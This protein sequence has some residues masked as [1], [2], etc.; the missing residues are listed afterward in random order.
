[1]RKIATFG[2]AKL[3]CPWPVSD[4]PQ[5]QLPFQNF[6]FTA[7][8]LALAVSSVVLDGSIPKRDPV[9]V[10]PGQVL[11]SPAASLEARTWEDPLT[12]AQ[13]VAKQESERGA[14]SVGIQAPESVASRFWTSFPD[15]GGLLV[16]P[17]LLPSGRHLEMVEFRSRTRTAVHAAF[18]T[19]A[20]TCPAGELVVWE[21]PEQQQSIALE[22]F[23]RS[24]KP[25]AGSGLQAQHAVVIWLNLD[26]LP[27][28]FVE[29]ADALLNTLLSR[30]SAWQ[31]QYRAGG[32]PLSQQPIDVRAIGPQTSNDLIRLV[33]RAQARPASKQWQPK[34]KLF[35][36]WATIDDS[37]ALANML[38]EEDRDE[39]V[40]DAKERLA[41]V[42]RD[43]TG[44][45]LER[46][47]STDDVLR[48][49]LMAEAKRRSAGRGVRI[50]LLTEN[51][52]AYGRAWKDSLD[53]E[54]AMEAGMVFS[55]GIDGSVP[56]AQGT[57]AS[58]ASSEFASDFPKGRG[59][60]DYIKRHP[61]FQSSSPILNAEAKPKPLFFGL[62]AT[63]VPDK[64][65]LAYEARYSRPEALLFTSDLDSRFFHPKHSAVMRNT[66]IASHF[67]LELNENLQ[68]SLPPFRDSYQTAS[69]FAALRAL[70]EVD[71]LP[72]DHHPVLFEV[73]HGAAFRLSDSADRTA[74]SVHPK[75]QDVRK[76]LAKQRKPLLGVLTLI[77]ILLF[78]A[79]RREHSGQSK[80][81]THVW[82]VWAIVALLGLAAAMRMTE[83][84]MNQ[85]Y[86]GGEFVTWTGGISVWPAEYLRLTGCMLGAGFL[87]VL[88]LR[89]FQLV[90]K[91]ETRWP[92]LTHLIGPP[93][94]V[95]LSRD[96]QRFRRHW[97][98]WRLP[99]QLL[100]AVGLLL[101]L[102]SQLRQLFGGGVAPIRGDAIAAFDKHMRD[103]SKV[104][105]GLLLITIGLLFRDVRWLFHSLRK[106]KLDEHEGEE[107]WANWIRWIEIRTDLL[108][109][110]SSRLYGAVYY[111]G[112]VLLFIVL[113]RSHYFD[114][115]SWSWTQLSLLTAAAG[116][117]LLL[118]FSLKQSA[119]RLRESLIGQAR[120]CLHFL[121]GLPRNT[122]I[123]A[124][125][126]RAVAARRD[127]EAASSG[128]LASTWNDPVLRALLVPISG[129][130]AF[131]LLYSGL[132]PT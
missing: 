5:R 107:D 89:Y 59:Q 113:G 77:G 10:D 75:Q 116:G 67:G 62:F 31:S 118:A 45:N 47:T 100:V 53:G 66:V 51:N 57:D 109:V 120:E 60:V 56:R 93:A 68:R 14:P 72:I 54:S 44:W 99:L 112:T 117:V 130:G 90:Y 55:S 121:S 74:A 41:E 38:D 95:R 132:L 12:L 22:F 18:S 49:A 43:K 85:H 6:G 34:L 83:F 21:F 65:A 1:V 128:A 126:K 70:D 94:Q 127:L 8:L 110:F 122:E 96:W 92:E 9:G 33:R 36:P 125:R 64:I 4:S 82:G 15:D 114:R 78:L 80:V 46:T 108:M 28:N 37:V 104:V 61:I 119:R 24:G 86:S 129:M 103:L 131:E 81:V 97:K 32:R 87:V 79:L 63:E 123:V 115:W 71:E 16:M 52:S 106:H 105:L 102:I 84:A 7:A 58:G 124:A 76:Q 2:A 29:S 19:S 20:W 26:A 39:N 27:Q 98:S 25:A 69:Y 17:V 23:E 13:A 11:L 73:G 111:S 42:F 48:I 3:V 50:A 30:L 35:S 40:V 101:L 91:V 88:L